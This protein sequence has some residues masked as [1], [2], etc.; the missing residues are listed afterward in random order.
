MTGRRN[1]RT[2]KTTSAKVDEST[3]EIKLRPMNFKVDPKFVKEYKQFALDN[4]MKLVDL[5]KK[6]F[7]ICKQHPE[8]FKSVHDIWK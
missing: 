5:L 1:L 8:S 3:L 7:D 4:D 2:R 6:S